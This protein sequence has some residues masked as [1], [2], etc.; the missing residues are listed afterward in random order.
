MNSKNWFNRMAAMA[1]AMLT[2]RTPK[3][4]P[5]PDVLSIAGDPY[6]MR[7]IRTKGAFGRPG[8]NWPFGARPGP[9]KKKGIY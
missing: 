7:V 4:P 2:A 9:A 6:K 5:K 3:A 8:W 1:G